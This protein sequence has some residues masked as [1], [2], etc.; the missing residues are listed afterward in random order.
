[1]KL[2]LF[3]ESDN[4]LIRIYAIVIGMCRK[5]KRLPLEVLS[6]AAAA[7]SCVCQEVADRGKAIE[8]SDL[9]TSE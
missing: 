7:V 3:E 5:I 4:K 6:A 8:C 2:M 9:Q 1:M